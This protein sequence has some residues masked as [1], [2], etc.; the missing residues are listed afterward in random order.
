MYTRRSLENLALGVVA[1]TLTGA[2]MRILSGGGDTL[3]GDPRAQAFLAMCYLSVIAIAV[4]HARWTIWVVRR[5]PA[6]LILLA[7]AFLSAFWAEMPDLVVRRAIAVAGTT[8]FGLVVAIRL[9]FAEQLKLFRW[10]TRAAAAMC[11]A[12]LI[13]AP[14]A[15]FSAGVEGSNL[16]GIFNH[17]NHLGAAMALGFLI[18]WFFPETTRK[19]KLLRG[20]SLTVYL[21]LL[22]LS[23]SMT[24]VVAFATTFLVVYSF[25]FLYSRCKIPLPLLFTML[26][27]GAGLAM[28]IESS[29]VQLLGRSSDLTGRTELWSF[30]LNMIAKHPFLGFG[31]SGFW[32][33]ASQ[34]S[35][36]VQT[37]LG[38]T[39]V[40]S[41]NGYL[42]ILLSLGL[43][44]LLLV[45][46]IVGTGVKRVL[47]RARVSDSIQEM[48]PIA[49]FTF[50]LI[51]NLAE[52]T[53]LL[54]NCLEWSICITT[55][56][57]SDALLVG[58]M[59]NVA[60]D[61]EA[62]RVPEAE[63]A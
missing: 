1:L 18:E 41:H 34:E 63:Y 47:H 40:Y 16:R 30:T 33:G 29:A 57:S 59:S 13:L 21:V 51:H 35:L 60:D 54:Q 49:F 39:P 12:V 48:W 22:V 5:N 58:A 23:N 31:L 20:L 38:W 26:L 8:L 55:V 46:V 10:A 9:T 45:L 4:A 14:S 17:K 28:A 53:I 7:V 36:S 52:C 61:T 37:L 44:G 25:R 19:A 6:I 2:L 32:M 50:F 3:D 43:V 62:S 15:A 42:E 24:S 56:V 27:L 11:I